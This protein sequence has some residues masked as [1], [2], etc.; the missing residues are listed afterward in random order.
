MWKFDL[1]GNKQ[2]DNETL[3]IIKVNLNTI[4]TIYQETIDWYNM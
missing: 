1:K 4:T 2:I 3:N